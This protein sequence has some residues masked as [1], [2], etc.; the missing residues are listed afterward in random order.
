[1][2]L[3]WRERLCSELGVSE[4]SLPFGGELLDVKGEFTDW[5][6]AFER[7][8][9]PLAATLLVRDAQ[10]P[11]VRRFVESQNL[12][13]SMVF[14]AVPVEAPIVRPIRASNSL[15][16]RIS[17]S[18]GP[19]TQWMHAR[20]SSDY[21]ISCVASPDELDTVERGVTIGGQVKTSA[22][23]YEK[24]DRTP[25]D[26]RRHWILGSDNEAKTDYLLAR[27]R[28]AKHAEALAKAA[29]DE[30]QHEAE[31]AADR[32]SALKRLLSSQW[33]EFDIAAA[34]ETLAA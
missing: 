31:R 30:N 17:V 27:L 24:N 18:D 23:R 4:K 29:L 6:G 7:V 11:H 13:T 5:T 34:E 1:R 9:R 28:E 32:R 12:G 3:L 15:V 22:R 14:E 19:F 21:D 26:E 20:L 33:Q 8:L 25:I 16:K 10:L 2:L